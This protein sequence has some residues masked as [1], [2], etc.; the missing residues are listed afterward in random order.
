MK[1]PPMNALR[2]FEAVSRHL[3]VSK[4]AEEL[5]VSQGAVSQQVRNLED[6]LG[7]ELFIRTKNTFTLSEEGEAYAAV[8][9]QSLKDISLASAEVTK[10]SS[11]RI[12]TISAASVFSVKWL[13]PKLERFYNL[14]PE[15]TVALAESY[16]LATFRNDG[17]DGAIRWADAHSDGLDSVLLI[18]IQMYAVASP[19]YI[20]KHGKLDDLSNPGHH[21]LI[22]FHYPSKE[23]RSQHIL[24]GNL[25]AGD[26]A[27]LQSQL[28][29]LPDNNQALFAALNGQ[30]IAL[31]ANYFV[32]DEIE[33]GNLEY[34]N[35]K[36]VPSIYDWYFVAP[37]DGSSNRARDD[38]RDWLLEETKKYRE[39]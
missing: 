34:V 1:L 25:I 37:V 15:V 27:D 10:T 9:Q 23:L 2:A 26:I 11:R 19:A 28:I 29:I 33:A 21:T 3:S 39:E 12:L 20:A 22:E 36:P 6:H 32:D 8:V 30:G 38:F 16:E 35:D 14:F 7:R 4:A 13:I 24:W 5:C 18:R 31:L 17:I